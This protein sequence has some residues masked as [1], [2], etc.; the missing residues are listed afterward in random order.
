MKTISESLLKQN[1]NKM[2]GGGRIPT[3]KIKQVDNYKGGLDMRNPIWAG[4]TVPNN[5]SK[6]V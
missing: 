5:K 3:S 2:I 1:T 4:N 6:R